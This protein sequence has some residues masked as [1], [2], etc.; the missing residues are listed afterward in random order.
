MKRLSADGSVGLPHVR[1]GHCQSPIQKNALVELLGR[2]LLSEVKRFTRDD[3]SHHCVVVAPVHPCTR[4]IRT[5]V[6]QTPY[7]RDSA[8]R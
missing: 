3:R 1:V 8:C 2:F 4:D 6:H 5:P 7:R